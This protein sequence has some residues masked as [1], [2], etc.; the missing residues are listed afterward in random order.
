[1]KKFDIEDHNTKSEI[2]NYSSS[3]NNFCLLNT[4]EFNKSLYNKQQIK[5]AESARQLQQNLGY[6]GNSVFK[7][8]LQNNLIINCD[9]T[10]DDF[11]RSLKIFGTPEPLL[12]GCMTSPSQIQHTA[13]TT[14]I[15]RELKHIYK[16]I[17]LYVDL[18]YINKL[19]FI[20]TRSDTIDF[21]TM[22]FMENKTKDTIIKFLLRIKKKV[23][24]KRFY[25]L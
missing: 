11:E 24:I 17:Q 18:C 15:P 1:M 12:K 2:I 6:P 16:K 22:D 23:Y 21:I 19:V 8:I 7:N 9:V 10:V 13:V 5:K 14:T 20:V 25:H 4:V 3:S